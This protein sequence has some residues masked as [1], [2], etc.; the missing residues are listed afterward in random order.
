MISTRKV[1][2]FQKNFSYVVLS[3]VLITST[4]AQKISYSGKFLRENFHGLLGSEHFA[5]KTF[6]KWLQNRKIHEISFS[7]E[8][9]PLYGTCSPSPT[10]ILFLSL[11]LL[12][13]FSFLIPLFISPLPLLYRYSETHIKIVWSLAVSMIMFHSHQINLVK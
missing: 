4:I 11:S 10:T 13:L 3:T 9:V 8:S 2:I 12:F 6:A 1:H 5:E 7:L